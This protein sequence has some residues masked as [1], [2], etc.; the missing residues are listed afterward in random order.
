MYSD[1]A[2]HPS[3]GLLNLVMEDPHAI[4][5]SKEQ[6]LHSVQSFMGPEDHLAATW[7]VLLPHYRAHVN[8]HYNGP[9]LLLL[10]DSYIQ[11]TVHDL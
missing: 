4:G 10:T 1:T 11:H 3:E 9:R 6:P 2:F 5:W 8:V 7:S